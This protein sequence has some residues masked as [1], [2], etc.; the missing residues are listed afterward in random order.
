MKK[1]L[2][3]TRYWRL[4]ASD[5]GRGAAGAAARDFE[6]RRRPT[7]AAF[8]ASKRRRTGR[9]ALGT[10]NLT[11]NHRSQKRRS[12]RRWFT[13]KEIRTGLGSVEAYR[14]RRAVW[15]S[16]V[17][18]VVG[19]VGLAVGQRHGRRAGH[20]AH[21]AEGGHGEGQVAGRAARVHLVRR[22]VGAG[23]HRRIHRVHHGLLLVVLVEQAAH[24]VRRRADEAV[25]EVQDLGPRAGAEPAAQRR[26]DLGQDLSNPIERQNQK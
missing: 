3:K 10:D 23:R 4:R 18:T 25:A 1:K 17:R 26:L 12:S 8:S 15:P 5:A 19:I 9:R 20:D 21:G 7:T 13:L 16:V 11:A 24:A 14:Q 2:G 6:R 22:Q